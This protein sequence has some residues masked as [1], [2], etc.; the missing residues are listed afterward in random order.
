VTL[1]PNE[2]ALMPFDC[3]DKI[4]RRIPLEEL[5]MNDVNVLADLNDH[6]LS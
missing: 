4:T 1:H 2:I 5:P 3:A 6:K